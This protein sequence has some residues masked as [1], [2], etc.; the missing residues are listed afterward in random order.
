M[1]TM[2]LPYPVYCP[3]WGEMSALDW[4][5]GPVTSDLDLVLRS[6]Y[7]IAALPV[8]CNQRN[9]FA[10]K[11]EIEN[12]DLS[13]FD[14]VILTDIEYR[15]ISWI[16]DW[17]KQN[18]I[19]NYVLALGGIHAEETIDE[20]CMLYRPWWSYNLLKFNEVADTSG[21]NKPYDFDLL[22]GARR[23]HR[24]YAMLAFQQSGLIDNSIVTYREMFTGG[25]IDQ[26]TK[27][28]HECFPGT[29]L[30]Y[31]YVSSNLDPEWEVQK[32]LVKN[33]SPYMPYEIYRRTN[34]TVVCET[35]GTSDTFFFSEK[36][37]KPL[38]GR[39][40][41]V[42]FGA[43]NFLKNL[44]SLGFKT[45]SQVIDEQYD[46]IVDHVRRFDTAFT[47]VQWLSAQDP[48]EIYEAIQSEL[49]HNCNLVQ[50]LQHKTSQ[51]MH[52][53]IQSKLG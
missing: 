5:I 6:K 37:T 1:S 8:M 31:P 30:L 27:Q 9:D 36:T 23:P 20:T 51:Q 39:R 25:V 18:G 10:Y 14:L 52:N 42:M 48:R 47:Q 12:L 34:Y 15:P 38:L 50:T 26:W 44:R 40:L 46:S 24:D 41:F 7:K 29:K 17:I 35:L 53:L 49:E 21:Y 11:P 19:K 22:L 16:T 28:V 13:R 43:V 45:F 2:I 3:R 33:I 32:T 4:N